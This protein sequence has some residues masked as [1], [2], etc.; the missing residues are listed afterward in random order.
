MHSNPKLESYAYAKYPKLSFAK[1]IS[2]TPY[3]FNSC[4]AR[5]AFCSERV[6]RVGISFNKEYY[7]TTPNYSDRLSEVLADFKEHKVT[8]S[9]S[10]MEPT[11]SIDFLQL[12]QESIL[13]HYSKNNSIHQIIMYSNLSG[14]VKHRSRIQ[15]FIVA[16]GLSRIEVSRHHYNEDRNQKI[17]RFK[18]QE[19]IKSNLIF[20]RELSHLL[21]YTSVKLVCVIQKK[22]INNIDEVINYIEWGSRNNINSFTFRAL[23]ILTKQHKHNTTTQYIKDNYIDI[24]SIISEINEDDNFKI[25]STIK[26]YYYISYEYIYKDKYSISF[27]ASDYNLMLQKHDSNFIQKLILYPNGNVCKDW[28]TF[29]KLNSYE[30]H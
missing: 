20:E 19:E 12:I 6:Q 10:G 23:A 3:I 9:L 1:E 5:C 7:N 11:E 27:E 26:G 21:P 15:Q 17:T 8:L 24:H 4:S 2:I 30:Q 14:M 13:N 28:N 18:N 22:G 16:I 29:Q 25:V